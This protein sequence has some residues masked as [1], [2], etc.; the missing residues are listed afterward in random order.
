MSA[1]GFIFTSRLSHACA[2][3][4]F[5]WSCYHR[6]VL[7]RINHIIWYDESICGENQQQWAWWVGLVLSC[8]Y[9]QNKKEKLMSI[10]E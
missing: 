9:N 5:F 7:V 6:G 3:E 1:I 8:K 2:G 4:L 10:Y